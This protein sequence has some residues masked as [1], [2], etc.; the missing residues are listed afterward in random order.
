MATCPLCGKVCNPRNAKVLDPNDPS[1]FICSPCY[2]GKVE[3]DNLKKTGEISKAEELIKSW[4]G[5]A[6]KYCKNPDD[7]ERIIDLLSGGT[8]TA[9]EMK[10]ELDK[11]TKKQEEKQARINSIMMTSGYNFEGYQ[12]EKYHRLISASTVLGTGP[13]TE[14]SATISDS[15]GLT[16]NAFEKKMDKAKG[17]SHRKLAIMTDGIGANAVI[18]VDFDYLT[19]GNNMIAVSANGTAVSIKKIQ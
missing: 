5:K 19:L 13:L 14:I 12:I 17:I 10:A 8:R 4:E 6:A 16:S 9:S 15:F 1:V 2:M 18:G 7:R 11:H 3:Y